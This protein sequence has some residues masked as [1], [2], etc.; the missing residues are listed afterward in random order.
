MRYF[1]V[2]HLKPEVGKYYT[3]QHNRLF[4]VSRLIDS[5]YYCHMFNG[6]TYVETHLEYE[7]VDG[8]LNSCCT[9][10]HEAEPAVLVA[11]VDPVCKIEHQ[12][13]FLDR[14]TELI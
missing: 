9:M 7:H 11:E 8:I 13:D 5:I 4:Y 3:D 12:H 2:R 10:S 6:V 14:A 1:A